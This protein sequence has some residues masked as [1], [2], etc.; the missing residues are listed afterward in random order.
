MVYETS[1]DPNNTH[2]RP[3]T[4]GHFA[5][6]PEVEF[7]LSDDAT[8][9]VQQR[10]AKNFQNRQGWRASCLVHPDTI[11]STIESVIRNTHFFEPGPILDEV[12]RRIFETYTEE[13]E[14]DQTTVRLDEKAL[15]RWDPSLGLRQHS[16][17]KMRLKRPTVG[18]FHWTY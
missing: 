4:L 2:A 3:Y 5:W 18:W 15:S 9:F 11:H 1:H 13:W 6:T 10:L 17:L 14:Q 16:P 7:L 12:V 8:K